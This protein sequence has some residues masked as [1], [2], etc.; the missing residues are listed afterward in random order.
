MY[1]NV[2]AKTVLE[3]SVIFH[4]F[5][6]FF[7]TSLWSENQ[8]HATREVVK[9]YSEWYSCP[10]A[11]M[12]VRQFLTVLSFQ[13]K[14]TAELMLC[15]HWHL[16]SCPSYCNP[17]RRLHWCSPSAL[18]ALQ[19]NTQSHMHTIDCTQS[20]RSSVSSVIITSP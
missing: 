10:L 1:E 13:N 3:L 4:F 9:L 8:M 18:V 11:T 5:C 12:H 20:N 17:S 14:R 2:L 6:Q 15:D 7:T 16:A 19:I